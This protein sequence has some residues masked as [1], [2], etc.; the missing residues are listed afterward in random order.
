MLAS[1]AQICVLVKSLAMRS[2]ETKL[3]VV[4]GR[5]CDGQLIADWVV[6][7]LGEQIVFLEMR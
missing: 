2:L 5:K 3:S 6:M 4:P 7:L 1:R